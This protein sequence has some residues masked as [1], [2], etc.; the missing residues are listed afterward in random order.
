MSNQKSNHINIIDLNQAVNSDELVDNDLTEEELENI[1]GGIGPAAGF[2][3]GK[4]IGVIGAGVA[5]AVSK[6]VN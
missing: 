6:I 5:Y 2:F 3:I 1:T 4:A